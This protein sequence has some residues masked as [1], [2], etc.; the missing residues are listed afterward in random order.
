MRVELEST[1]K[2]V[3]LEISGVG[4]PA[5]LWEGVTSSGIKV[6]AYITRIAHDVNEPPEK[7]EEFKR[8]LSQQRPPSA[9]GQDALAGDDVK[10]YTREKLPNRGEIRLAIG[11]YGDDVAAGG[12]TDGNAHERLMVMC[13]RLLATARAGLEDRE[14]LDAF[15]AFLNGRGGFEGTMPDGRIFA[16][17]GSLGVRAPTGWNRPLYAPTYREMLDVMCD[18]RAMGSGPSP[19]RR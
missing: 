5:R 10:A 19:E 2:V 3:T 13:D 14:R 17:Q 8:E 4:V 16:F 12:V 6:H 18:S 9:S 11:E 1:T 7:V 15:Q